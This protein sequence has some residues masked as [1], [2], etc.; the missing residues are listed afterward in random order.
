[1][2]EA[3]VRF[4]RPLTIVL[5]DCHVV[6]SAECN[7][8]LGLL[9][10]SL[11][12]HVHVV[13]V[14]RSDPPMRLGRLR[15][16]GRIAE[17]RTSDLSFTVEEAQLLL[18]TQGVALSET[19]LQELHRLTEGWPAAVYL[20]ALYLKG[21]ESPDDFVARLSGSN[22]YIA[23]YL[24]EEVLGRQ[25]PEVRDFI[26]SMSVFDRF[27]AA[28][29]DYVTQTRSAA[30]L[31]L[32]LE[33]TNLLL[34][35]LHGR[36]WFRFH[37][38]FGAFARS[39]LEVEH[40]ERVTELHRRG[41]QWFAARNDVEQAIHHTMAAG[42]LEGAAALV[43]KNWLSFFDAGRSSTVSGWLRAFRGTAV[44]DGAAATV[45]GAWL[46]ALTGDRP[47]LQR[48]EAAL[49]S[50][51]GVDPL[52]DG[53]RS[54][55][56]ALML[57]RGLFG[58]AGPDRMLADAEQA[59]LLE[60]DPSTP[61][62][63]VACAALGHAGFVTGDVSMARARLG[64][65]ARSQVAPVTVRVLA[66]GTLSLCEA[67]QGNHRGECKA[68]GPGD[69]PGDGA[70][71]GGDAAGRLRRHRPRCG[72]GGRGQ[73]RRSE[74]GPRRRPSGTPA[75]PGSQFVAAHPPPDRDR[76]SHGADR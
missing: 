60:P 19:A 63:A 10:E 61:W 3:L 46:A 8:Q 68:R 31:L 51:T 7:D 44:D 22:R 56:S 4:G 27:D 40:P 14:S 9:I 58:F 25:D 55:R 6:R 49:E 67:E 1:M 17:I 53:T 38:L 66:L 47:E 2:I 57:I 32:H 75:I 16:E 45:T 24:S 26:L 20:A 54:A 65:A 13:I 73:T 48:R 36:G 71:H 5:E 15:V 28:L 64:E 62:H 21:R 70:R 11:P 59:I 72:A 69:G 33:R 74:G 37:H 42:D 34:I 43:Q 41:A 52:P 29:A 18:T 12:A 30:R 35:P 39:A 23:D 76:G 50:M